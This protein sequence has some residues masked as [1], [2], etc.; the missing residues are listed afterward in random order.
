VAIVSLALG[1]GANSAVFSLLN[2]VALRDLD[3]RRPDQL[4]ALS[5]I[6]RNGNTGPLSF[7]MFEAIARY[8]QVS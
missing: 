6:Q 5:A 7:P 2:T 1:I 3:V 4:V 8:Q